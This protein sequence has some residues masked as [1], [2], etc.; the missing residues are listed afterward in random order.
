MSPGVAYNLWLNTTPGYIL[1]SLWDFYIR[2]AT[3]PIN[4]EN[5][6]DGNW[7]YYGQLRF[8]IFLLD[9]TNGEEIF[10]GDGGDTNWTRQLLSNN[11][12]RYMIGGLG[13]EL[14]IQKVISWQKE[15]VNVD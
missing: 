9:P 4:V 15:E 14:L 6:R 2:I 7:N 11:K 3:A 13:S 10:L 1:L 8:N 5:N 12:E